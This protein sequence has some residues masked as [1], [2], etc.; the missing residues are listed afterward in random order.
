MEVDPLS[1]KRK[2]NELTSLPMPVNPKNKV[3]RLNDEDTALPQ[4][5]QTKQSK[6]K[7]TLNDM[8]WD[9]LNLMM[10]FTQ[11]QPTYSVLRGVNKQFYYLT[12]K[13]LV[14]LTFNKGDITSKMFFKLAERSRGMI[15]NL[16]IRCRDFKFISPTVLENHL[17]TFPKLVD[18]D[19]LR[20]QNSINDNALSKLINACTK[21]LVSFKLGYGASAASLGLGSL[22][23]VAL[24]KCRNL[25]RLALGDPEEYHKPKAL[26]GRLFNLKKLV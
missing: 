21:T 13:H 10:K 16:S 24:S 11:K 26:D 22:S 15:T 5:Q 9:I 20:F 18:L 3:R 12:S 2:L 4:K 7:L 19:L 25:K 17:V 23:T 8:S 14:G 6:P 1:K